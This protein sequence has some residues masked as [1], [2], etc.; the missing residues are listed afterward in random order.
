MV[1]ERKEID[2]QHTSMAD[3]EGKSIKL[4]DMINN[5]P[6][7]IQYN[8]GFARKWMKEMEDKMEVLDNSHP[9]LYLKAMEI[10]ENYKTKGD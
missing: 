2:K 3:Y 4:A 5:A 7:I 9:E 6:S 10:I 8:P 1:T